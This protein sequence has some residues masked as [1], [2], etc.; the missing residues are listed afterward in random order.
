MEGHPLEDAE[1]V[2]RAKRGDVGAYEN[3]VQRYQ[4][5][6]FRAAYVVTGDAG[7][8]EDA[9]QEGFVKAFYALSRFRDDAPLRPWLLTIVA[10]E[11]RNRRK[12]GHRRA[13][14]ALRAAG[15]RL[16]GEVVAHSPEEAVV[17]AERRAHLIEALASLRE[18]ERQ[19]VAC[20]YFL[21]LSEAET[22][23]VLGCPRGTVKSRLSRGLAHLRGVVGRAGVA[24]G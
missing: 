9:A 16:D 15:D 14:L 8:A 19:A 7:E 24:R 1:L 2:A 23:D 5:L 17:A 6:A 18:E 22:A 11:A 21:D 4:D 12:S 20:R 3:L 10:N 13:D